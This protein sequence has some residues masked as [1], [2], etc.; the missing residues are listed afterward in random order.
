M[1]DVGCGW[2]ALILDAARYY[3]VH[4]S[5]ITLSEQQ[6]AFTTALIT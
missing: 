5:G 2:G 4:A 6:A 3:G 1:L